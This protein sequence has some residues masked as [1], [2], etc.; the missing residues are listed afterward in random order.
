M[1]HAS[2]VV[3]AHPQRHLVPSPGG[4]S[5]FTPI[6]DYAF[7]SDCETTCLIA[8][9]GSVEWMCVPRPDSPSIFGAMLDRS[10]G[11][12]RLAPYGRAVPA[13]SEER[14][15]GKECLL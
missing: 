4:R 3:A 6:A 2:S 5:A 1:E 15:V 11:H 14:R 12:F 9:S 10:A 13:R 7:L 8:P